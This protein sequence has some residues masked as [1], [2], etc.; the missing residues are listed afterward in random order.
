MKFLKRI[1]ILS[2]A[3]IMISMNSLSAVNANPIDDNKSNVEISN[4]QKT[5][6]SKEQARNIMLNKVPGGNIIEFS[7]DYD[8]GIPKYEG[9]VIKGNYE[10]SI[11]INANTGEILEFEHEYR[12]DDIYDDKFENSGINSNN[13]LIGENEARNIMLN[14]VPGGK[15]IFINIDYDDGIPMYEGKI[16]KGNKEYEISINGYSGRILEFESEYR[17][18]YSNSSSNNTAI[19]NK[20]IGENRAKQIMLNKIPG[21]KI[22]KFALDLDDRIPEYKGELV[23]GYREYEIS[24]HALNGN[25]IDFSSEI[26]DDALGH[27]AEDTIF[28]FYNKGY[29]NGYED[30]EFKPE[31]NIT[32]AEFVKTLNK[33]FNLSKSSGVI[34]DDTK[35]HWAKNEIDIAVTNGVCQGVSQTEFNPDKPITREEAAVMLANYLK[36]K[37]KNYDKISKFEDNYEISSWAKDS[38]EALLEGGYLKGTSDNTISP[39]NNTNRAQA[40]T[41]FSRINN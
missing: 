27:W 9:K 16:V 3:S 5:L 29:I 1:S 23:K 15:I 6:I 35:A 17:Y 12:D 10:Y 18:D 20:L 4:R 8:D 37:D 30:N 32:R 25:I 39:K 34:F 21:A 38:V 40:V 31:N 14:K 7:Y 19:N 11:A 24:V 41:L 36:I 33:Y 28:D 2:L 13:K 22:T 26:F